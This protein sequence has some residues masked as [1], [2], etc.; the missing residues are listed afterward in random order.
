ML[1]LMLRSPVGMKQKLSA[2][3][4]Y[5]ENQISPHEQYAH[6]KAREALKGQ[7]ASPLIYLFG[8]GI[9]HRSGRIGRSKLEDSNRASTVD[10]IVAK[11]KAKRS[12]E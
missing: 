7:H 9:Y 1:R 4:F 11:I 8:E 5:T 2:K 3:R 12:A 10:D 6:K